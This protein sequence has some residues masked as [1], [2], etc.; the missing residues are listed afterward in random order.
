[1]PLL[2]SKPV[3]PTTTLLP[4]RPPSVGVT[5]MALPNLSTIEKLVVCCSPS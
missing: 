5:P 2:S 1:M 3:L 4:K